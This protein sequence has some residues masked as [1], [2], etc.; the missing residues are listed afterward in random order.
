MNV[1]SSPIVTARVGLEEIRAP[2]ASTEM[3]IVSA[4]NSTYYAYFALIT[5]RNHCFQLQAFKLHYSNMGQSGRQLQPMKD[6][7]T[8]RKRPR[9]DQESEECPG[10]SNSDERGKQDEDVW[11]S[12]GNIILQA[13]GVAFRVYR[14]ILSLHSEVF[15]DMF[16]VP[17]P[18]SVDTL[19]GCPVVHL[20]DHPDEL[21]RL[22][23]VL[24]IDRKYVFTHDCG[25]SILMAWRR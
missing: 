11:F 21:R 19:D 10:S 9:L 12:D 3:V 16:S 20:V 18:V 22:L 4:S 13:G 7:S 1:L 8:T 25:G 2:L 17:Q 5:T 6:A 14:G 15:A 24:F 23:R